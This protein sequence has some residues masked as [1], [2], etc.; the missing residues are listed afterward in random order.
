MDF[1]T[2]DFFSGLISII[3]IDLVLG[4]DNAILIA[5]ATRKLPKHQRTKAIAWGVVGA[6]VVRILMTIIAVWLLQIPLLKFVGG[7]LLIW[8]AFNLLYDKGEHEEKVDSKDNLGAAIRTIIMADLL[9]GIDNVLAVAGAADGHVG[10]VVL[11]LL[12]SIP[13][14]VFGST[15]ILKFIDRYPI[16]IYIG[17]AVIAVVAGKMIVT[18]IFM[19]EHVFYLLGKFDWIVT[20]LVTVGVVGSGYYARKKQG[21]N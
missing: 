18:D 11:G 9:M 15:I 6:I 20:V 1:L 21:L 17:A 14:I 5:L 4:G 13:I 3:L 8:I 2:S 19:H 10:L 16:I 7:V 12:I